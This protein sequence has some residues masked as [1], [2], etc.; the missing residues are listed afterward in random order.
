MPFESAEV[1]AMDTS[2]DDV[3]VVEA[4]TVPEAAVIV[5]EPSATAV[6]A[7]FDPSELPM[8]TIPA[9]DELHATDA[10]MSWMEPFE[11]NPVAL[12]FTFDPVAILV[13]DGETVTAVRVTGADALPS[14]AASIK[15][16]ISTAKQ[17]CSVLQEADKKCIILTV[18]LTIIHSPFLTTVTQESSDT[19]SLCHYYSLFL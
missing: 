1:T 10:V 3:T 11:K 5:A 18:A 6:A 14:H 2:G 19:M 12:N 17:Q 7:P 4:E 16:G 15:T 13:F 8:V 9:S